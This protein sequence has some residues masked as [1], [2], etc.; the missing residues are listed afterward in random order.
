MRRKWGTPHNFRLAFI[1]KLEKQH[2]LKKT[3]EMG[4]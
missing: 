4:Q 2:L 3:L 1:G